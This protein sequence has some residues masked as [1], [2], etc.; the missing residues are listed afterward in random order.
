ML[1]L[2]RR[3]LLAI[4][5]VVD[6]AYNSRIQPVQA[7][8]ITNRQGT[9]KRYLE[10]LLQTLVHHNILKSVRGARGGYILARERRKITLGDIVRVIGTTDDEENT[11]QISHSA[12]GQN[13][14]LPLWST[15]ETRMLK[16]MDTIT[17]DNLCQE[18][19][20]HNVERS[21]QKITDFA[22]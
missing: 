21:C 16:Y 20:Q 14:I 17:L 1:Q 5:A 22:I 3:T 8:T 6:I 7:R 13:V 19:Q 11:C 2:S 18:A 12:L 10:Q 15:I 9:S 4:E